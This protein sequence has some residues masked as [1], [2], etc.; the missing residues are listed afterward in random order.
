MDAITDEDIKIQFG[1]TGVHQID[2]K[3]VQFH[4]KFCCGTA[5]NER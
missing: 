5:V 4:A 1:R 3:T 2:A